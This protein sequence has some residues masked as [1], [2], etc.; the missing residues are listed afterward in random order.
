M[1]HVEPSSPGQPD[2]LPP[3]A[4]QPD[5]RPPDATQPDE[6]PPV[7]R[8]RQSG[9]PLWMPER[10]VTAGDAALAL[11]D[12][13]PEL[14]GAHVVQLA[15]GWDNTVHVVN[16]VWA[17]RF[18]RR[19]RV[20]EGLRRE[21]AWL[22]L[23]APLLPLPI[24]VPELLG[25]PI[26]PDDTSNW[27]FWGA[28]LL[29]GV[30]LCDAELPDGQRGELAADVG[31]FLRVLH[32]VTPAEV[33]AEQLPIDPGRRSDPSFRVPMAR[34][35]M[36]LLAQAGVWVPHA[37]VE[38]LLA[39]AEKLGGTT[40]DLVLSH[41]DLHLRHL[42]VLGNRASAIIDWGDMCLADPAVDLSIAFCA[43]AGNDRQRL[44][45]EYGPLP[46]DRELRAR[47]LAIM[48][49]AVLA[50]YALRVDR[51]ALLRE[52]LAGIVRGGSS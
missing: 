14:L 6:L 10:V 35:Q 51:P 50:E 29:P 9:E 27:P 26:V 3:D 19:A 28:R 49:G 44:F 45:D 38:A 17:V 4:T 16:D 40:A 47:A 32:Q 52:S 18:P 36:D 22:P 11:A 41:G 13:F 33:L 1:P 39:A 5:E 46:P 15:E 20:L 8:P 12:Q 42:L 7:L 37:Q 24:P 30:E 21:M 25:E 48:L 31:R 34:Q 23:L 2:E 43:F